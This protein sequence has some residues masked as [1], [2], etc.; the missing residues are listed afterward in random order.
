MGEYA[1]MLLD[2]TC[3]EGC[4]EFMGGGSPG[5]PRYCSKQCARDRGMVAPTHG[6]TSK[7][8]LEG[9]CQKCGKR[10]KSALGLIFHMRDKHHI[11]S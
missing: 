10:T 8:P 7:R 1:E 2:G 4:G 5:Y 9:K 6:E 11:T 3:C